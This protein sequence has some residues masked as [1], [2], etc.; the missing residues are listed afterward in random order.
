MLVKLFFSKSGSYPYVNLA[1]RTVIRGYFK[2]KAFRIKY[3]SDWY[4][5]TLCSDNNLHTLGYS[6]LSYI[7]TITNTNNYH[8]TT[9]IILKLPPL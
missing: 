1:E 8:P 6:F 7:S 9:S 5:I 3:E 4:A 2:L